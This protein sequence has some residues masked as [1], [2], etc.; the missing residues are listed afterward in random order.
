[1]RERARG[2]TMGRFG[3]GGEPKQKKKTKLEALDSVY[4]NDVYLSTCGSRA[5]GNIT[6]R[7]G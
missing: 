1:M 3:E 7:K 2:Q 6:Y 5:L 4:F